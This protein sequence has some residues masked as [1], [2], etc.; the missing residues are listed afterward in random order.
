MSR[1]TP[2]AANAIRELFEHCH[3]TLSTESLEWLGNL[4]SDAEQEASHIAATLNVLAGHLADDNNP[5][6]PLDSELALMLWGLASCAET[7]AVLVEV[8]GE[9]AYLAS[10]KK[11]QGE[12]F[13]V[14]Q[15]GGNE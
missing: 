2:S 13:E 5:V 12:T 1:R 14:V 9:A 7:V 8:S 10:K 11:S 6:R 4:G 15:G 3:D